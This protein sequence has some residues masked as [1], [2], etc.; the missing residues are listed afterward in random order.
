MFVSLGGPTQ[1]YA[2]VFDTRE[3]EGELVGWFRWYQDLMPHVFT[4]IKT[5]IFSVLYQGMYRKKYK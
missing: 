4:L 3:D 1:R 5:D 2:Y